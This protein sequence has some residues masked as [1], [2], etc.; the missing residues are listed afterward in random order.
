[1][2]V[3]VVY[4]DYTTGGFACSRNKNLSLTYRYYIAKDF[5]IIL[6]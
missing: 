5:Q 3:K 1:M 2:S 6:E 4:I